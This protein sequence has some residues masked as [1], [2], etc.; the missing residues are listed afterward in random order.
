MGDFVGLVRIIRSGDVY[1]KCLVPFDLRN[2]T[3]G[4]YD[5]N[6]SI[7]DQQIECIVAHLRD[8]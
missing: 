6:P 1:A 3:E 7:I 5:R 8:K 2:F 4:L